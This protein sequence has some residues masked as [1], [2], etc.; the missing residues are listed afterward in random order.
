MISAT[1]TTTPNASTWAHGTAVAGLIASSDPAH[2]G[3][4]PGADIVALRVFDS[5][6][7]GTYDKIADALQWVIDNHQKDNI[8]VVNLSIADGGNYVWDFFGQDGGI[9]QRI[10]GLIDQLKGLHIPV[11]S[12]AG[13]SFK[14]DQGMG[15]TA[16]LSET[17][18][19]TATDGSDQFLGDAQRLGTTLGH[20]RATDL[21]APGSGLVAPTDGNGFASVSGTSFATPLVTGS[22][23]LLQSIYQQRYG[24]LPTVDQVEQWLDAGARAVTRFGDGHHTRPSRRGEGCRGDP[25][26]RGTDDNTAR[27]QHTEP[28][29]PR[30]LFRL[31]GGR[32]LAGAER[33]SGGAQT[34]GNPPEGTGNSSGNDS[35]ASSGETPGQPNNPTSPPVAPPTTPDTPSEDSDNPSDTP[36]SPPSTSQ[37]PANPPADEGVPGPNPTDEALAQL[38]RNGRS[39]GTV[40]LGSND[41]PSLGALAA[42]RIDGTV[43]TIRLWDAQGKGDGAL[44]AGVIRPQVSVDRVATP[45][46]ALAAG[47]VGQTSQERWTARRD[48]FQTARQARAAEESSRRSAQGLRRFGALVQRVRGW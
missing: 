2:P 35:G 3:V 7:K 11:V 10:A 37:P 32:W 22:V 42:F 21:A 44:A 9:G 12:A 6:N 5:Q 18:S 19:V 40:T 33:W 47:T 13:N 20:E 26:P 48:A 27:Y 17:I 15:F 25:H 46:P 29:H 28:R 38:Y 14:G 23:L 16:I 43:H 8:S 36:T 45:L 30:E 41:D 34:P 24:K 31:V 1:A 39:L 4:A